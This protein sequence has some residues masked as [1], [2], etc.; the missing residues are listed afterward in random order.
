MNTLKATIES[1]EKNYS[2]Y[3]ENLDGVVATG[4]TIAEIKENLMSAIAEFKESC[5]ELGCEL[6]DELKEND[7]QI[8]FKM[9]VKSLLNI[10]TGI[11]TKSGLERITGINQK[12]LWHYA[13]GIST[14]RKAQV[15]K[16]ESALHR[17]GTELLSVSL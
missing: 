11:F 3:I 17:L 4:A 7:Y 9:D 10:Y 15:E 2:A 5:K 12:Q 14:P 13:N 8:E 1:S 16:I 6:P